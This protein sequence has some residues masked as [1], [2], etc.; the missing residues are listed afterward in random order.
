MGP[1]LI[2]LNVKYGSGDMWGFPGFQHLLLNAVISW[3][4]EKTAGTSVE[5]ALNNR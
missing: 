2:L 4:V 3:M 1:R 5:R